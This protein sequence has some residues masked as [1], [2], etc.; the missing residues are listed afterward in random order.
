MKKR[1]VFD[2]LNNDNG[3]IKAIQAAKK[4]ISENP[5]YQLIL[6][7]DAN[8]INKELGEFKNNIE[9]VDNNFIVSI[10]E[11]PRDVLRQKS[12]MSEAFE[13]L[14]EDKADAILSSGDSGAYITLSSLKVKRLNGISRPAFMPI[15]PSLSLK[16]FLLLDCGANIN[17]KE[18][19]FLE[20][21]K[22]ASVY[23]KLINN[24][25][26]TP[27]IGLLNLGTEDYKGDEVHKAANNL[28]K[29]YETDQFNY[30]GFIEPG[31]AIS[32]DF[33]IV[34]AD[35]YGGNIFL[36]TMENTFSGFGK[37]LKNI[38]YKNL[39]TKISGLW[40]KP[41][42]RKMKNRYDYRNT[43][44]AYIVGLNKVVVKAHGGSDEIAFYNA[45]NQVKK[46]LENDVINKLQQNL[47]QDNE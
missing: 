19:F 47:G 17:I 40:L 41:G 35:G 24:S 27:K 31:Q 5:D 10:K 2:V 11:S 32:G 28:L 7:G 45:L 26:E 9:V 36:K 8:V 20:W 29:N 34:L 14:A 15:V 16:N 12:S 6:V 30:Y 18:E 22:V 25:D 42:L 21:A 39:F 3:Q 44:G 23:Y 38:I 33:Q 37:L 13:I 46:A 4:F 1:I 43:G